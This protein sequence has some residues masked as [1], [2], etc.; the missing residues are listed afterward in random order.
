MAGVSTWQ[1]FRWLTLTGTALL[2][3]CSSSSFSKSPAHSSESTIA[4]YS[5]VAFDPATGD[6]GVAVQSKFFSVGTV[7]PWAR[8]GVGAI[9]TQAA[10]NITYGPRGLELL[11]SGKSAREVVKLLTEADE[12]RDQR[13]LGIVDAQGNCASHTGT[14]CNEWAGHIERKNFCVQGNI[15]AGEAVVKAM[16]DAYEKA[17]KVEGSELADWLMAALHAGEGA[18]G[19]KRGRQSA[20]LLVVRDK[21][22]YGG[23]SDRYIDL[24]VEDHPEP[25]TELS[26]LLEIHKRFYARAHRN[27]PGRPPTATPKP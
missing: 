17:Q 25:N 19:D 22:G 13:Q 23:A 15:L 24:R 5:I 2:A 8:A 10:G 18:G 12:G 21:A 7:V 16:A 14:K 3:G 6:L 20:A 1:Q 4:T 11:Q 27:K 26:R 9:A